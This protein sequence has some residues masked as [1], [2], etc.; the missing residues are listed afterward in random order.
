MTTTEATLADR[1]AAL[2]WYHTF[3]LPGGLTTRGLYDHRQVVHKLPI[4][5]DLTGQR[6]LDLASSDGFFAFEMAR[7]GAAEVV[8]V[9]LGD[10]AQSDFQGDPTDEKRAEGAGRPAAAFELVR[11]ATGLDVQRLDLNL[12]DVSPETVGG[13]Y[14]LVFMGNVL[15]HLRD[16]H[17]VLENVRRVTAGTFLSFEAINLALTLSRPWT[18]TASLWEGDH[19]R[20]WTPNVAAHRRML[21]AAGF[22][23]VDAAK[24]PVFQ[25]FGDLY[26]RWPSKLPR[27]RKEYVYW[28]W[29]RRVGGA[30]TWTVTRPGR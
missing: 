7:R 9:D 3:D 23:I 1:V 24:R 5:E 2:S 17:L 27:R 6:C 29:Q 15:L 10:P 14:D 22:E 11:E 21:R 20:W 12:Y 16:P 13:A 25:P 4:P 8:S 28:L 18:P 26:P 19:A 30:C